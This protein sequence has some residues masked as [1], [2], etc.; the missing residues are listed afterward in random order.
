M[1]VTMLMTN[2]MTII[3]M[4]QPEMLRIPRCFPDPG[5]FCP[6]WWTS[7]EILHNWMSFA[8]MRGMQHLAT[9]VCHLRYL[10]KIDGASRFLRLF[11]M[12]F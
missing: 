7:E 3:L 2:L 8:W 9:T 1:L 5:L 4:A 6:D 12:R 10:L 11:S